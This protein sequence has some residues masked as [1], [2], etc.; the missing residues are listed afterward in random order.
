[1]NFPN[2]PAAVAARTHTAPA[3]PCPLVVRST[4]AALTALTAAAGT[5]A[6]SVLPNR[7]SNKRRSTLQGVY[8][9]YG[10]I[11]PYLDT[12]KWFARIGIPGSRKQRYLGSFSN[13]QDAGSAFAVAHSVL[14][15]TPQA[16][17]ILCEQIS[18]LNFGRGLRS[19]RKTV[20]SLDSV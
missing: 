2:A 11:W 20:R 15:P 17:E 12:G 5:S 14:F 18:H 19:G 3:L 13:E 8:P 1:M 16:T 6:D 7:A 9:L 10:V 4:T